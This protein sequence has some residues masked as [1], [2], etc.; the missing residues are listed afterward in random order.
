MKPFLFSTVFSRNPLELGVLTGGWATPSTVI[1][2]RLGQGDGGCYDSRPTTSGRR[3][4]FGVVG[5]DTSPEREP[6]ASRT[7]S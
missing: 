5:N 6:R 2:V 7:A 3:Y 4:L 1:R